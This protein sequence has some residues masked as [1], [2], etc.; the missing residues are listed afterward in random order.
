[1][2]LELG[3]DP[4]SGSLLAQLALP[5]WLRPDGGAVRGW[6]GLL[7]VFVYSFLVAV[8][9]PLP[10]EVVLFGLPLGLGLS[11]EAELALVVLVSATGKALGSVVA[12]E[13]EGRASRSTPI[14]RLRALSPVD[15]LAWTEARTAELAR[16]Y[17]YY[18]LALALSVPGFPDTALIY[19]FTVLEKDA[20]KFAAA[21]F[22]G[23]VVR[24]LVTATVV[25]GLLA[26]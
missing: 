22:V 10:G 1:M 8:V 24:L 12:L 13:L 16:R 3:A 14:D 2:V 7:V 21:T 15:P 9:L 17:G 23:T 19:A 4:L 25:A 11:F 6:P 5:R 26:L 20:A 18:G